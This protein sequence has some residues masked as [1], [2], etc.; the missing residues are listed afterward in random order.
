MLTVLLSGHLTQT[1]K[2]TGAQWNRN[3]NA[4]NIPLLRH[5]RMAS[6]EVGYPLSSLRGTKELTHGVRCAFLGEYYY[7][8]IFVELIILQAAWASYVLNRR[9]HRDISLNNIILVKKGRQWRSGFLIDW[10]MSSI[11]DEEGK[12]RDTATSVSTG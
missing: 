9:L 12:A 10:E 4:N 7:V 1:R 8:I 5:Y 11:A 3:E 6:V 2:Y